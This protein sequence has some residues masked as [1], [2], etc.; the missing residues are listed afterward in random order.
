MTSFSSVSPE[1]Q[2]PNILNAAG[3]QKAADAGTEIPPARL[4]ADAGARSLQADLSFFRR[5]DRTLVAADFARYAPEPDPSESPAALFRQFLDLSLAER[6]ALWAIRC[7]GQADYL[8]C[9]TA[10]ASSLFRVRE[11]TLLG[12][13]PAT[14]SADEMGACFR[15]LEAD[16]REAGPLPDLER[17]GRELFQWQGLF[18]GAI[19]PALK[20]PRSAAERLARQLLLGLKTLACVP[21]DE[22][23]PNLKRVGF[24]AA[25]RGKALEVAWRIPSAGDLADSMLAAAQTYAPSGA[26]AFSALER[27][28]LRRQLAA[29]EP[30]RLTAFAGVL[31][32]AAPR[33]RALVQL[34]ILLPLEQE[35]EAWKLALMEPLR[36]REEIEAS[37]LYVFEPLRLDLAECGCGRVLEAV[38][39]LALHA[40]GQ[41]AELDRAG[42][43][44]LDM[45]EAG[46]GGKEEEELLRN[47]FNWVCRYSLRLKVATAYREALA[48]LA[49]SRILELRTQAPFRGYPFRPL[50]A[51]PDLFLPQID[52]DEHR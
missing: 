8:F 23:G 5:A 42:G 35:H 10:E 13:C 1:E 17:L 19:G 9:K 47:P 26:G 3:W 52:T 33:F 30:E 14:P 22:F 50:T 36:V 44:Q 51:L 16:S 46:P 2:F 7:D 34:P 27:N 29:L 15:A 48:Y 18:A 43:R 6:L 38:E 4:L 20:W 41:K 24:A 12:Q 21:D 31:R 37:D 39:K 45:I 28:G 49:A 11:E 32:L 40:A 25:R